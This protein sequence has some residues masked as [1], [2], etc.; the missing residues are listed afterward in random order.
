MSL[1]ASIHFKAIRCD[2]SI[3]LLQHHARLCPC[4]ADIYIHTS[5]WSMGVAIGDFRCRCDELTH[6][7]QSIMRD[8]VPAFF[9]A[10]HIC[11]HDT[12]VSSHWIWISNA[13]CTTFHK[14]AR[15]HHIWHQNLI[16][17]MPICHQNIFIDIYG[18][19][20]LTNWNSQWS[21]RETIML[22]F[23]CAFVV[24]A[25]YTCPAIY[26][27][28]NLPHCYLLLHHHWSHHRCCRWRN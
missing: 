3:L 7:F 22:Y 9:F 15:S 10:R 20:W 25:I 4:M 6:L 17:K 18:L 16:D 19:C 27:H 23:V 12:I 26:T 1:Q 21:N 2:R 5:K 13:T 8:C 14:Y 28:S 11:K 24:P